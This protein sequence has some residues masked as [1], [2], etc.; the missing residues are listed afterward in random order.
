MPGSDPSSPSVITND[1]MPPA[2]GSGKKR[3]MVISAV[4][5]LLIAAIGVAALVMHKSGT[6][7]NTA[8]ALSSNVA[9]V[10]IS[11]DGYTPQTVTIK[12]GQQ[13][14]FTNNDTTPRQLSADP[15]ALPSF[16]TVEPLDQGDSYTYIFDQKGT[17]HYYDATDPTK[18][19][20]TI[21]VQ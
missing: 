6:G 3:F 2:Q 18:F 5:V 17:Y 7:G 19:V 21:T 14:T 20:G 4:A 13:V 16:D 10:I 12:Q 11:A 8:V 9:D 15:T 1:Y